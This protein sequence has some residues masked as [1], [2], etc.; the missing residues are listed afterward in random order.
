VSSL[1]R[2]YG[3]LPVP[4]ADPF[5]CFVWEALG[6]QTTAV[7]R[8]AA[9]SALQRIPAL[10]P[11]AMFR[12]P[13]ARLTAAI[14]LAGPYQEQRLAAL[15]G[16]VAQFRRQPGLASVIRGPL[17]GARRALQALPRL[18]DASVTRVLLFGGNHL[19]MPIDRNLVRLCVRM[20]TTRGTGSP[21]SVARGVRQAIQRALPADP[22]A[23]KRAS[24]YLGHHSV[25]TC[26]DD[27]H[28]VVCPLREA[29]P[30]AKWK[31]ANR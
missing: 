20:G 11:D 21:V 10:T 31:M 1:E 24:L 25:Q 9:Y 17:R 14:A 23:F 13:R 2:F 19:V 22:A 16:G 27:P 18:A 26:T 7:R 30:S 15:L 12:A 5:R 6:M 28:C 3:P 4:P 8:D 29:C